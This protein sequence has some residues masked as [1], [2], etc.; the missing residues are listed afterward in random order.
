[1]CVVYLFYCFIYQH[2][3]SYMDA[4]IHIG[5]IWFIHSSLCLLLSSCQDLIFLLLW[6]SRSSVHPWACP[7]ST[8]A[9]T[10]FLPVYLSHLWQPGVCTPQH[11]KL[12]LLLLPEAP[13]LYLAQGCHQHCPSELPV[14]T[15]HCSFSLVL[16]FQSDPKWLFYFPQL[17][18][19]HSSYFRAGHQS[20]SVT[21]KYPP[22]HFILRP[23]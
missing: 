9:Q 3:T 14:L 1:M 10:R 4:Q 7:I 5:R 18:F 8:L 12:R 13:W 23:C 15:S 16:I 2:C 21:K 11:W 17:L 6:S 19:L 20:G 22:S